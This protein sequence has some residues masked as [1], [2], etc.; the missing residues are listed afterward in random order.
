MAESK[1][2]ILRKPL[3]DDMAPW[4]EVPEG[5]GPSFREF[6]W[7]SGRGRDAQGNLAIVKGVL[8]PHGA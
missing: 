4:R 6:Y 3:I 1:S 2:D 5:F 8:R 7:G